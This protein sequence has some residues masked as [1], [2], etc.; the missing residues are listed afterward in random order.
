[1]PG[2]KVTMLIPLLNSD[3]LL[4]QSTWRHDS[5]LLLIGVAL[6][7]LLLMPGCLFRKHK[8]P[9]APALPAPVR[10]VLLPLNIPLEK[11][12]LRWMSLGI[13]VGTADVALAAPDIELVPVWESVPAA[14]QSLGEAR[15][16]TSDIAELVATRLSA[17]W[18]SQGEVITSGNSLTMRLDFIP[19]KPTLVPFRYEKGTGIDS[20]QPRFQEAWEQFLRYL[21]VRPLQTSKIRPMDAKRLKEIADALDLEY[22]WFVAAKPGAS[23]KVVGDLARSNPALARILF[24]PTL[25]PVLAK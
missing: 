15:T 8:P 2:D 3:R 16:V 25:Y 19:A 17:R 21:I 1:M 12:D 7:G 4:R 20:M 22:G 13:L 11:S 9:A 14:L 10:A 18:S 24:S 23:G 5:C 6:F